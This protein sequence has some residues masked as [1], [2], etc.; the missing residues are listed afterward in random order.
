MITASSFWPFYS[1]R[2]FQ[3][4]LC[5]SWFI[6]RCCNLHVPKYNYD[7]QAWLVLWIL[8]GY[9]FCSG[10]EQHQ[11]LSISICCLYLVQNSCLFFFCY[12]VCTCISRNA[13]NHRGLPFL[14]FCLP[15]EAHVLIVHIKSNAHGFIHTLISYFF[16]RLLTSVLI[17]HLI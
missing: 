14:F 8:L 5:M 7:N 16:I 3:K 15:V 12:Q 4:T 6:S 2:G 1:S 11:C 10:N 13:L 9:H 17:K